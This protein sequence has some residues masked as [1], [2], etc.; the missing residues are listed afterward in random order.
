MSMT[1]VKV[2]I[3]LELNLEF[4]VLYTFHRVHHQ[5]AGLSWG[6]KEEPISRSNILSNKHVWKM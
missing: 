2:F 6:R 5:K 4:V 1:S 3:N